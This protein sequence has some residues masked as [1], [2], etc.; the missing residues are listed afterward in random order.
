M[1]VDFAG[2]HLYV[3]CMHVHVFDVLLC[4]NTHIRVCK[5]SDDYILSL[6]L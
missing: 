6:N 2:V 4:M 5:V 1:F 3:L